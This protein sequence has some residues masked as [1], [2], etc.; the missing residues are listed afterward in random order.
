MLATDLTAD[1]LKSV[2]DVFDLR[3]VR[4]RLNDLG[5]EAIARSFSSADKVLI[6]WCERF[7]GTLVCEYEITFIDG[8]VMTGNYVFGDRPQVRPSLERFLRKRSTD[9]D[10]VLD[11]DTTAPAATRKVVSEDAHRTMTRRR[12]R[13]PAYHVDPAI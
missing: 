5:I 1:A 7:G 9:G 11:D 10:R 8:N 12:I 3:I 2:D 13:L 6:N 4:L